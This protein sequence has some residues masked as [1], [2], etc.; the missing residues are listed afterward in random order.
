[1]KIYDEA[2]E[3]YDTYGGN[4]PYLLSI[5]ITVN[6]L[7]RTGMII[8]AMSAYSAETV[9]ST[10]YDIMLKTKLSRDEESKAMLDLI[11][12]NIAYDFSYFFYYND[13]SAIYA[14]NLR[15]NKDN[16]VSFI[17]SVSPD[18][19]AKIETMVGEIQNA[20]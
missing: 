10:Y 6:D 3:S 14:A 2:Q 8:E 11:F 20:G 19:T 13:L 17:T 1:M 15:E 9:V 16:I 4:S 5:P 7:T 12:K 18:I